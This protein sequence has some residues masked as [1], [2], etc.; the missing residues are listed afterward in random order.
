MSK[1]EGICEKYE[2]ICQKYEGILRNTSIYWIWHSHIY[3]GLGTWK[4]SEHRLHIVS[5]IWKIPN[6]P[7]F[8]WALGLG[9]ILSSASIQAL[10]FEKC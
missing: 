1:Y 8:V 6:S 7:P 10:G 3:M 5:E 9:K 2:E 4:N